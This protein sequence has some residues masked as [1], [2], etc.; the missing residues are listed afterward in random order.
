MKYQSVEIV[1][2]AQRKIILL[3]AAFVIVKERLEGECNCSCAFCEGV[4]V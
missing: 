4:R 2:I 1:E 3:T